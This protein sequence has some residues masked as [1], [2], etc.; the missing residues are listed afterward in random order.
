MLTL[1]LPSPML[2]SESTTG[3]RTVGI[4]GGMGP[5][6]TVDFYDKL[7][8]STPGT[9]DQDHLGVVL[10]SDPSVP[11]R[12]RAVDGSGPDPSP[13]LEEGI[14]H[15]IG[16]GADILVVPCNTVHIYLSA[17]VK[18]FDIEFISIIDAAADA[19]LHAHAG[20]SIGL[21][22]TDT[23]LA[24]GLY[25]R[26]LE[27]R[28]LEATLPSP[29]MQ[30]QL[31]EA[32][33]QVKAGNT[34]QEVRDVV[35]R[36]LVQLNTGSTTSVIAACTEVSVILA[37]ITGDVRIVDSSLALAQKAVERARA[38]LT[39]DAGGQVRENLTSIGEKNR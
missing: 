1:M 34:G 30:N 25:Q 32:I 7:V 12:T 5:A 8:Q 15:L 24:S 23:T 11:D 17:I 10:W 9:R 13:W 29:E 20:K 28:G 21:L 39:I 14:S 3:S 2:M 31:K 27:D 19:A 22:A 38:P 33:G 18:N 36:I 4:L 35:S 16:A 26:A 6:A 37:Q